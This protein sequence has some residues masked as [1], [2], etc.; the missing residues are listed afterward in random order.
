MAVIPLTR[1]QFLIPFAEIHSE[2]GGPIGALLAKFQL[3]SDGQHQFGIKGRP[4]GKYS[5]DALPIPHS[6]R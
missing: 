2:I 4:D 1:C 5:F 6:L 3:S